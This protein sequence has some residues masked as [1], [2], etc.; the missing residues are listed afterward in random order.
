[1]NKKVLKI[2]SGVSA[3]YITISLILGQIVSIAMFG[4]E[5]LD[6]LF[7]SLDSLSIFCLWYFFRK[8][9]FT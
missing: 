3:L 7:I 5:P 8:I 4:L 2:L 1:M 6:I 9:E